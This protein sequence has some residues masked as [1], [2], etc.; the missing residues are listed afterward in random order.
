[1]EDQRR[2]ELNNALR[3]RRFGSPPKV[4]EEHRA[5]LQEIEADAPSLKH[6]LPMILWPSKNSSI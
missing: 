1:M 2:N 3:T 6:R 4:M 5:A